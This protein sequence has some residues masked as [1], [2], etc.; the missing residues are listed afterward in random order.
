MKLDT[1]NTI[2][3]WHG[4]QT[5]GQES[6]LPHRG[7]D[8]RAFIKIEFNSNIHSANKE[9][10]GAVISQNNNSREP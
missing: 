9:L 3:S 4:F 1:C 6:F 2:G 5:N 10:A 8:D 7:G